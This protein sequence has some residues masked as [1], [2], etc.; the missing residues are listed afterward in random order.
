MKICL[1]NVAQ[2]QFV[3]QAH[4]PL[5]SIYKQSQKLKLNDK[6]EIFYRNHEIDHVILSI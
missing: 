3:L 2:A 5:C 6:F 1:D 4:K